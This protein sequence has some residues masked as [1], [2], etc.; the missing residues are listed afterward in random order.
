MKILSIMT[1]PRASAEGMPGQEEIERM[2]AFIEE[3]RNKGVLVDTGGRSPEMFELIMS[4]D[5]TKTT[6]TDGPFSEAKEVV[7]G[8]ALMD[9]KDEAEAIA[10]TERFLAIIGT[11]SCHLHEV[12]PTP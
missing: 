9:V 12:G 10:L 5:G 2:N 4:R 7:G 3:M 11:G 8:Y 1:I 6:T